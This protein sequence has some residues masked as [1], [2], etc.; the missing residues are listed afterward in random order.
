MPIQRD[1]WN[2]GRLKLYRNGEPVGQAPLYEITTNIRLRPVDTTPDRYFFSG[3]PVRDTVVRCGPEIIAELVHYRLDQPFE[4]V[5]EEIVVEY[6]E[7]SFRLP[8]GNLISVSHD[9]TSA[10]LCFVSYGTD[11]SLTHP[12]VGTA[13][14]PFHFVVPRVTEKRKR[15]R[16]AWNV[17]GF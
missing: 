11:A 5:V 15:E 7:E 16:P 1:Y 2:A 13:T 12:R 10:R 3:P 6:E 9:E 14:S 4:I 8:G 17:Y